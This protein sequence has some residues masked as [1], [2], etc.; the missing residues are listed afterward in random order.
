[1]SLPA[2]PHP[3]GH[4]CG[5]HT[6]RTPSTGL[7]HRQWHQR[8]PI[9]SQSAARLQ[10]LQHLLIRIDFG[11]QYKVESSDASSRL[12]HLFQAL[13]MNAPHILVP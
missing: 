7:R 10:R 2:G 5:L 1:M 11:P 3:I 13:H 8:R 4:V 9:C 6:V 12:Y